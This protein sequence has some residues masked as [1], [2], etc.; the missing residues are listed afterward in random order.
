MLALFLSLELRNRAEARTCLCS[1]WACKVAVRPQNSAGYRD[2]LTLRTGHQCELL[3]LGTQAE[4]GL[5]LE[6]LGL[7]SPTLSLRGTSP[8]LLSSCQHSPMIVF[9]SSTLELWGSHEAALG[10]RFKHSAIPYIN[11][12]PAHAPLLWLRC[13]YLGHSPTVDWKA[14][15]EAV[16][17]IFLA[18][19]N[20]RWCFQFSSFLWAKMS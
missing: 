15:V 17:L 1:R 8:S 5:W 16:S 9:P 10:P 7:C 11:S 4:P 6:D 19:S 2:L 12:L 18:G 13:L 14:T 20:C 3:A